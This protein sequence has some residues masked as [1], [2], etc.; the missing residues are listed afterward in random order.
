M[1]QP[2]CGSSISGSDFQDSQNEKPI[3][4]VVRPL[5]VGTWSV[6]AQAKTGPKNQG[7]SYAARDRRMAC[8]GAGKMKKRSCRSGVHSENCGDVYFLY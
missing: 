3:L 8:Q 6:F 2:H 4:G 1:I 5:E 7:R